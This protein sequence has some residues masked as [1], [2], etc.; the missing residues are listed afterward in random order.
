MLVGL[1]PPTPGDALVFGKNITN[2]MDDVRKILRVCPQHDI[3]FPELT[4]REHLELFGILKGVEKDILPN[5]VSQ[6]VD[7]VGGF[8]R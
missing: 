3:L 1:L 2:E 6:M 4:V 8:G 7:E 5:T